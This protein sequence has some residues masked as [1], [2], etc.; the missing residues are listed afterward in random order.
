MT[1]GGVA[2]VGV[3]AGWEETADPSIW[4]LINYLGRLRGRVV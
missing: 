4:F 3:V 1:R 2:Q